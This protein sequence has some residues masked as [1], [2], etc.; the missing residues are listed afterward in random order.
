M[1]KKGI[2]LLI[3]LLTLLFT[4]IKIVNASNED[5][6]TSE[7]AI[8]EFGHYKVKSGVCKYNNKSIIGEKIN[9][10]FKNGGIDKITLYNPNLKKESTEGIYQESLTIDV[11]FKKSG[12]QCTGKNLCCPN[13][14]YLFLDSSAS[15][16]NGTISY[17]DE[18]YD[19]QED[20]YHS[21]LTLEEGNVEYE[22]KSNE[23]SNVQK[24]VSKCS[25]VKETS[26]SGTTTQ[27]KSPGKLSYIEYETGQKIFK[28]ET[29]NKTFSIESGS[30]KCEE[31]T[32]VTLKAKTVSNDISSFIITSCNPNA[33][34][35]CIQYERADI[36]SA[37]F[38]SGTQ[39]NGGSTNASDV[40]EPQVGKI[41]VN[42]DWNTDNGCKSY[43][44][45]TDNKGQPAYYLQ[46]VFNLM[47]YA[48]I[49]LLFVL[50]IIDFAKATASSS[51][52][53]LKK[54][55]KTTV[56]RLIIAVIIFLLPILIK[57]VF[58]LL[59]IY[60]SESCMLE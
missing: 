49:V 8:D 30:F 2:F 50:S 41:N 39:M 10:Y 57:F 40:S 14:L 31:I 25:L 23:T 55:L 20:Q 35:N 28:D 32:Y 46:F 24:V 17:I 34:G 54:A 45:S 7:Y 19:P 48:A 59:G 44:G 5:N 15:R 6:M 37:P 27:K 1:K 3:L 36:A 18:G 56:K 4:N 38:D 58:E 29:S 21:I 16:N 22:L 47:K 60:S 9:V 51:D 12:Q 13:E 52:D 26:A 42:I 11:F 53:A 43:L 33:D